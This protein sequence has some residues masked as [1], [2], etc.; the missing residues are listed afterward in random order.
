M[1]TK[2]EIKESAPKRE[3]IYADVTD[4]PE[5]LARFDQVVA[6]TGGKMNPIKLKVMKMGLE[7]YIKTPEF[8][9]RL[10]LIKVF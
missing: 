4:E 10:K 3:I 2:N 7:A 6:I 1:E 9:A 8:Q 5:F